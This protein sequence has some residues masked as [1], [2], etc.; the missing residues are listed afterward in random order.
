MANGIFN[1]CTIVKLNNYG[2][3]KGG[4]HDAVSGK[5]GPVVFYS[6]YGKNY[7]EKRSMPISLKTTPYLKL[8]YKNLDVYHLTP[9]HKSV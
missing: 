2:R 1:T 6:M 4:I 5:V 7:L 9:I 3:A 8:P